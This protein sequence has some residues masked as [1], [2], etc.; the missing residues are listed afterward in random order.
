MNKTPQEKF[1]QIIANLERLRWL[2]DNKPGKYVLVNIPSSTL[3]AVENEQVVH[4]M[5]VVVG[6]KDR[7]TL[8]FIT[9]ITGVRFNPTWT[10]PPTIKR[11][12]YLP[13]L[14]ENPMS[15]AEK[16]IDLRYE[17]QSID[18]N[19]VNWVN[20]P[21][22]ELPNL[23]MVQGPGDTNP[24]GHIRI[25]MPN[26]YNIYLH[27]TT[28]PEYFQASER[29]FSSGCVRVKEPASLATFIL[30][31]NQNWSDTFIEDKLATG[32][33]ADIATSRKIPVYLLYLTTWLNDD[34]SLSY[35]PDIYEWDKLILEELK[36]SGQLQEFST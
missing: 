15:L 2:E 22:D 36:S 6:R 1:Y 17:G 16:G 20:F 19:S 9:E 18:P 31:E 12:D 28:T 10:V 14:R 24:L 13:M 4:E 34:G 27:D 5:P 25:L 3:W 35:G 29:M 32:K 21:E 11:K 7:P 26:Q 30:K 23:Q 8:S 33:T